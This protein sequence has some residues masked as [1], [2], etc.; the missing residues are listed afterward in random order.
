M[1]GAHSLIRSLVDAGVDVCFSNPGTTEMHLVAAL[2]EV[3]QMRAVLT[4]FEGVAT[5]AADGYARM[6]GRP[7]ATLLHL[8]PGMSNGLANLH[9]ARRART[10]MVNLI[11]DHATHH[12]RLDAPLEAD[13]DALAGT[14]SGWVRRS[15]STPDLGADAADA[16]SAASRDTIATLVVPSNVAW[17]EGGQTSGTTR[18]RRLPTVPDSVVQSA[19]DALASG[20]STVLFLGGGALLEQPLL[21]AARVAASTGA[22][23]MCETFPARMERG[24]G[25]PVVPPLAYLPEEALRQLEGVTRLILVGARAPVAFFAYPDAPGM[26]VPDGCQVLELAGVDEDVPAALEALALQVA[27]DAEAVLAVVGRPD[28]PTGALTPQSLGQVVAALLPEQAVVMDEGLTTSAAL[29][30][31]TASAPRHDWLWLTGGAIG[32]GLPA[33]TGAAVACPDRPVISLQADGS[34]MYTIQ[35]LWTQARE[36]LDVTTIIINNGAYAILE[37]ELAR[38]G[39][40]GSGERATALLELRRPN[41]DFTALA[42]GFGVPASRAHTADE[43]A[44][45]L[46]KALAEPGPHLIEAMVTPAP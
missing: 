37:L 19:A 29:V 32:M 12:K 36:Q 2:D 26:L 6:A 31:A 15:L 25:L 39:T 33:A 8:G 34:A 40:R 41:L 16:V 4:L 17:S 13:I 9:N 46:A 22:R 24:E 44:E 42:A 38:V 20:G 5:G 1:D 18:A 21:A 7:A 35:A 28:L 3:P 10:P 30:A 11:G 23:L 27:G 45:Q 43:L 14:V